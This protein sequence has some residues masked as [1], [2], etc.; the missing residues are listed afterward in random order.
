M[1]NQ[2]QFNPGQMAGMSKTPEE[3]RAG[4]KAKLYGNPSEP[5]FEGESPSETDLSAVA[6]QEVGDELQQQN[7]LFKPRG[8]RDAGSGGGQG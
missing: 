4:K 7:Q 2:S 3:N 6:P 5:F 1:G 8:D